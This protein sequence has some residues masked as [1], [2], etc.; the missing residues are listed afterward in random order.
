MVTVYPELVEQILRLMDSD[1]FT[2]PLLP[3][4]GREKRN[5]NSHGFGL[6][7]VYATGSLAK[8]MWQLLETYKSDVPLDTVSI[9]GNNFVVDGAVIESSDLTHSFVFEGVAK[10]T[11]E[12]VSAEV[13]RS[14]WKVI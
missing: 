11:K 1:P 3:Q 10:T 7:V 9:T 8:S 12:G 14:G 4:R 6:P 5:Q 2:A 13:Q